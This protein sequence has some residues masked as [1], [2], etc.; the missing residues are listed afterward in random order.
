MAIHPRSDDHNI[1]PFHLGPKLSG[2][3]SF[4]HSGM[5]LYPP[6]GH[7]AALN[8]MAH[9]SCM[10]SNQNDPQRPAK[11]IEIFVRAFYV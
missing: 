8:E 10:A 2:A 6:A 5:P 11:L 4:Y 7:S 9:I 1:R 3:A